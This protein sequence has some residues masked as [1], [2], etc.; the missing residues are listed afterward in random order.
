MEST[1]LLPIPAGTDWPQPRIRES[2][3][4]IKRAKDRTALCR[5]PGS[6]S[7][8]RSLTP[9]FR[10]S[11]LIRVNGRIQSDTRSASKLVKRVETTGTAVFFPCADSSPWTLSHHVPPPTPSASYE[12]SNA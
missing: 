2:R 5:T 7:R 6:L 4:Y 12:R 3:T 11:A 9:S 10:V 1:R 8:R